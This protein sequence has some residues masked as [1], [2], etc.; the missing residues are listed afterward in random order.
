MA[1][2]QKESL[3]ETHPEIAKEADGWD[4]KKFLA[5]SNKLMPWICSK[6]HKWIAPPSKRTGRGDGCPYC[7]GKKVLVGFNDLATT[8]PQ[9]AR[10][11][12]NW[13]PTSLSAGSNKRV[14]WR[15]SL[16]HVWNTSVAH[17][18]GDKPTGCPVCTGRLVISGINDI[19]TL[20]PNVATEAFGW[21][22]KEVS[23]GSNKKRNWR[24][25][26]F[27]EWIA[28]PNTRVSQNTGCPV[29]A[30]LRILPGY[31]DLETLFPVIAKEASGWDPRLV[32]AGDGR[33]REWICEKGHVFRAQVLKR[34]KRN[35]GCPVCS[36]RKISVGFNDLATTHPDIAAE[37]YGW[38]PTKIVAGAGSKNQIDKFKKEWKCPKGHVYVATPASRTNRHHQ[39]GCPFCSGN[40]N[41]LGFNDLATT[42]PEIAKEAEGW[43]P[44]TIRGSSRSRL[45]WRCPVGHLYTAFLSERKSGA[46]CPYCSGHKVLVGFNDLATTHPDIAAT[47][48][49]WDATSVSASSQYKK[50]WKCLEGHTWVT[51]VGNR[52]QGKGCPT[53]ANTGFDPN[54]EGW[55]YFLNHSDWQM[56]QIGITNYPRIRLKTHS[57][58]GWELIELRGPMD[59]HLVQQWETAILRHLRENGAEMANKIG[60]EPFDGYSESW[61]KDSF[62]FHSLREI[63]TIIDEK[64]GK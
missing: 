21:N 24:C 19:S 20:F 29:C 41:L 42:H 7:S 15:C 16:K 6:G 12:F 33:I 63:M 27:H 4:P 14:A 36:N 38:D 25:S 17:R 64:E 58:L 10:E 31:N 30:N 35:Q 57:K 1:K 53:C 13:D 22:P 32:G 48:D 43:D 62:T 5:G 34:T 23:P 51:S 49:G 3:A 28:S 45:S 50:K 40:K 54:D 47:A 46:G 56:L 26:K 52:K 2:K 44:R 8:H 18:T 37:A 9:V 60:I 39:S 55:L 61:L 11:A 59:G